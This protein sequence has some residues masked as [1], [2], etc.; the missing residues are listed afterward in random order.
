MDRTLNR[1]SDWGGMTV[2]HLVSNEEDLRVAFRVGLPI[3]LL[4][5]ERGKECLVVV[6]GKLRDFSSFQ[7][8][9]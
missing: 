2:S 9:Y 5:N 8:H 1:W 7:V 4:A 6:H 3:I